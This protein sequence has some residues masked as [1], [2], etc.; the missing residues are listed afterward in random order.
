MTEP[1][2]RVAVATEY[3]W[4]SLLPDVVEDPLLEDDELR[5]EFAIAVSPSTLVEEDT[6]PPPAVTVV[7]VP[8][9]VEDVPVITVQVVPSS[10]V[11]CSLACAMSVVKARRPAISTM[12]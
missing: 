3:D 8:P 9:P 1:S 10:S 4:P 5:A 11:T 2:E 7:D 6:L 12:R